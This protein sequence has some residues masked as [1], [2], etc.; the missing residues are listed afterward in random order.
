MRL[1]PLAHRFLRTPS[2]R[3]AGRRWVRER[4]GGSA[5]EATRHNGRT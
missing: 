5:V 2:Q 4:R 1:I 3:A